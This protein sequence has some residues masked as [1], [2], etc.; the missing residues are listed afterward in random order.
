MSQGRGA[1]FCFAQASVKHKTIV[2]GDGG[3]G[4]G[5]ARPSA[6]MT[7]GIIRMVV[8]KRRD[9]VSE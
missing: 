3:M 7:S 9:L 8:D 6:V 5:G 2:I 4:D 1:R